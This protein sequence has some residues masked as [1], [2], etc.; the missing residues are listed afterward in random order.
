VGSRGLHGVGVGR[1]PAVTAVF[2]WVCIRTVRESRG[3]G[4][5]VTGIPRG[6]DRSPS[7]VPQSWWWMSPQSGS[8]LIYYI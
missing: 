6:W 4:F 2:P 8:H 3:V 5:K 7:G 1:N